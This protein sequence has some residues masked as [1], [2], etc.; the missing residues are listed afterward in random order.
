MID[1]IPENN[2]GGGAFVFL[3]I[4]QNIHNQ[5][6]MTIVAASFFGKSLLENLRWFLVVVT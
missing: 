5:P 1:I 2:S 3:N 4:I 6:Y